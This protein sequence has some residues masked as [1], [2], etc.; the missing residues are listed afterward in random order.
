MSYT[1]E[2]VKSITDKVLN[3]AKADAVE[4]T[5][6]GGERSATRYA[7]STITANLVEHDQSVSISVYYGQKSATTS[8][9]QF[10]DAS[11]ESAIEQAQEL[12]RRRPDD[13]ELMPLVKPPQDYLPVD[14]ALQSAVDFGPAERARMVQQ[15]VAV[16]EKKG[17][18]GAGYV[19]KL[20]WTDAYANSE[21]LFAY[22]RYA[23][24]SFILTCRTPDGTGSGWAGTTGLKDV[25][26]IDAAAIT[27]VAAEKA[28]RSRK[29]RALEPGNYTV[30]LEPRPAAR[31]LSLILFALNARAAEEGRSFMSA[32]EKGQTKIG[33]KVFGEN[34]TIRSD[35]GNPVLRQTPI[36]PDGL[37]AR[38]ITWVDKGLVKNLFYDRYWAKKQGR[39]FTPANPGMSLVMDGGDATLDQMIRSTRRGLLVSFFWY[40]R[41]VERMTLLNTGMTR[42]GLFLIENGEIVGPAQNFRWNDGPARAFNNVSMLGRPVPMHVGEAYDNPGTALV[43]PMKIEDF[44]MTSISPAV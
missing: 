40:I 1:Q 32:G 6:A 4:V 33:Q 41:P 30:I 16:C 35:V 23:E 28:L 17:V 8:T 7:N 11:L 22:Y 15:S 37:A 39:A 36:G 19:P 21:G 12:A 31:F 14:A 5:F 3:M 13:P 43:P 10:D 20:H 34:I 44:R 38:P 29:P 2:F 24:A 25:A 42:D 26:A 27:E 9:H 18:L